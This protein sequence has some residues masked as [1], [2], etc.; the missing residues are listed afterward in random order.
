MVAMGTKCPGSGSEGALAYEATPEP[1]TP[2]V[3][4]TAK[5]LMKVDRQIIAGA[6]VYRLGDSF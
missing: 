3:L 1:L 6:V 4:S 2:A 5:T